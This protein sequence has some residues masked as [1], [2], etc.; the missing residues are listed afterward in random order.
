LTVVVA[1][2]LAPNYKIRKI[3]K[4]SWVRFEN[5]MNWE[6]EKIPCAIDS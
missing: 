2:L 4:N 6:R 5:F 3:K 1:S